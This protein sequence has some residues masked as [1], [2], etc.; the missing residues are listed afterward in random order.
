M[1]LVRRSEVDE[2]DVSALEQAWLALAKQPG[3]REVLE[4][5]TNYLMSHFGYTVADRQTEHW[6]HRVL[7]FNQCVLRPFDVR[8]QRNGLS[9]TRVVGVHGEK[10]EVSISTPSLPMTILEAAGSG[11][12]IIPMCGWFN[13]ILPAP[14][15]VTAD[16]KHDSYT[17]SYW[18]RAMSYEDGYPPHTSVNGLEEAE[19]CTW[20][21]SRDA[22][23]NGVAARCVI[24]VGPA[25]SV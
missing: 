5:L 10:L 12:D 11:S 19:L 9:S 17:F 8:L 18:S 3:E 6:P 16:L 14:L 25:L 1:I 7:G 24:A 23:V 4:R 2:K 20:T 21:V 15:K 22:L 13:Q